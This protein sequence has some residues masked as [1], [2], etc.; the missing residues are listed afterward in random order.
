MAV[1]A[2][3]IWAIASPSPLDGYARTLREFGVVMCASLVVF[4]V[5]WVHYGIWLLPVL[6]IAADSA[7][8]SGSAPLGRGPTALL[9]GAPLLINFPVPSHAVLTA[10]GERLW[11][12]VAISHHFFGTL[13]LLGLCIADLRL[14]RATGAAGTARSAG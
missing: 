6:A 9:A 11:F 4:P 8:L 12:R 1:L 5:S 14:P 10:F 2:L 7:G 13:L 3:S